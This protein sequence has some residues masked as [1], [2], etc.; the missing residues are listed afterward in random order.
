[1]RASSC[2]AR[3]FAAVPQ[4]AR[5]GEAG[6]RC[7]AAEVLME[8][9]HPN[10]S[11]SDMP[12][13][14]ARSPGPLGLCYRGVAR[15]ASTGLQRGGCRHR[16]GHQVPPPRREAPCPPTSV[17]VGRHRASGVLLGG[18]IAVVVAVA[19]AVLG[20]LDALRAG[21]SEGREAP[22]RHAHARL[23]PALPRRRG[24]HWQRR[25]GP[26]RRDH[27]RASG[28]R[29]AALSRADDLR[30]H[31]TTRGHRVAT[32]VSPS[33]AGCSLAAVLRGS[34]AVVDLLDVGHT[35][36]SG[37]ASRGSRPCRRAR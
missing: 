9:G 37:V 2:H 26:G 12:R 13:A 33:G 15:G 19:I 10:R 20:V 35:G 17:P 3:S 11:R 4:A 29:R 22:R 21:S 27:G 6:E 31:G 34:Q 23:A 8:V 1:M 25:P 32:P 18:G 5:S 14:P 28:Q 24:A 16:R 30:R 7:P 36:T